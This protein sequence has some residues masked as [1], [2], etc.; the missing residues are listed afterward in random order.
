MVV[1][2]S[3]PASRSG[4]REALEPLNMSVP[5]ELLDKCYGL[6]LSDQYWIS[7]ADAPLSWSEVNFF[8]TPFRRMSVI[9]CSPTVRPGQHEPVAPDN[10]SDGQLIKK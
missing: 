8:D 9:C 5:Q 3:I 6:S 10:T 2:P 7:P 4:L 1:E